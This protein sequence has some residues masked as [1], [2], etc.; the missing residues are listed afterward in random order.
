GALMRQIDGISPD[1]VVVQFGDGRLVLSRDRGKV[2][3]IQLEEV[4]LESTTDQ[5][6][7]NGGTVVVRPVATKEAPGGLPPRP[8]D[9]G[10]F[11]PVGLLQEAPIG[12]VAADLH[13][14]KR[15]G[16]RVSPVALTKNGPQG[17]Q[18]KLIS[19]QPAN[20][21]SQPPRGR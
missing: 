21:R 1:Q 19:G 14:E 18:R 12:G 15:I 20:G 13:A 4:E 5:P 3:L 17:G 6:I 10:T 7:A 9:L 16:V 8:C 11:V 2:I